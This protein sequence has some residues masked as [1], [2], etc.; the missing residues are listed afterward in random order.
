MLKIVT[1]DADRDDLAASLDE[2]VAEGALRTLMAGLITGSLATLHATPGW[3]TRP[4]IVS[5]CVTG[6]LR[7]GAW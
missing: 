7:S 1:D 6:G 5:W 2:L 4:G 3:L